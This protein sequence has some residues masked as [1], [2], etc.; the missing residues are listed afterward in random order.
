MA[1]VV[2]DIDRLLAGDQNVAMP[3]PS[4]VIATRRAAD[5][6]RPFRAIALGGLLIAAAVVALTLLTTR[7]AEP[8]GRLAF[9]Q[10]DAQVEH[11][12]RTTADATPPAHAATDAKV[13]DP[14][15]AAIR[16]EANVFCK[17]YK[18][19]KEFARSGSEIELPR[20]ERVTLSCQADG[21]DED[22]HTFT[23]LDE[24]IVVFNLGRKGATKPV[25]PP[26]RET[27]PPWEPSRETLPNPYGR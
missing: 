13:L 11:T 1:D 9:A 24:K 23:P 27:S 15:L 20:G 7:A 8:D 18:N 22:V 6:P 21:Y 5:A 4:A 19:G 2:S 10:I 12:A 16:I 17:V 14:S 25:K 3:D 26:P